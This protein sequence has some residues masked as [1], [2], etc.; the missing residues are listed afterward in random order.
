MSSSEVCDL[1]L[2]CVQ[3]VRCDFG[4][5]LIRCG[6]GVVGPTGAGGRRGRSTRGEDGKTKQ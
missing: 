2:V 3:D 5:V 1:S 4:V 6:E